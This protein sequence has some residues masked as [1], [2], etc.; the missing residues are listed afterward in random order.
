MQKSKDAVISPT[1]CKKMSL[2]QKEGYLKG[3]MA[4]LLYTLIGKEQ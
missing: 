4:K 2:R 3:G 1:I